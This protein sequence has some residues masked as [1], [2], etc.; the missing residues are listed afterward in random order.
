MTVETKT[1]GIHNWLAERLSKPLDR[2]WLGGVLAVNGLVWAAFGMKYIGLALVAYCFI[3]VLALRRRIKADYP[4]AANKA[5]HIG[6]IYNRPRLF[7][8]APEKVFLHMLWIFPAYCAT[9]AA[10]SVIFGSVSTFSHGLVFL[11]CNGV[12]FCQYQSLF[13]VCC[14]GGRLA[15]DSA[16][17]KM[18]L[19]D[20]SGV[21]PSIF[22]PVVVTVLFALAWGGVLAAYITGQMGGTHFFGIAEY[23]ADRL[24][25]AAL[26]LIVPAILHI[27]LLKLAT[28]TLCGWGGR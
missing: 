4:A 15:M 22:R 17:W 9:A 3:F 6:F 18:L 16:V 20:E 14:G 27:V 2:L 21:A 5:Y 7:S 1:P 26:G 24:Y 8:G 25:A 10:L 23:G 19:D 12:L 28:A 13:T 11:I